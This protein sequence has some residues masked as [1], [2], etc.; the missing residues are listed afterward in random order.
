[1]KTI[2]HREGRTLYFEEKAY[3]PPLIKKL[4]SKSPNGFVLPKLKSILAKYEELRT[5]GQ[6]I[7]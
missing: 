1:V 6:I 7:D 2:S 4:S 3:L 5:N